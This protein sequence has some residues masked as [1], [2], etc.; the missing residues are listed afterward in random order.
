MEV[1]SLLT[2]RTP[3][4]TSVSLHIT[5]HPVLQHFEGLRRFARVTGALG[6][7]WTAIDGGVEDGLMA[8]QDVV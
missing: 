7:I 5:T 8:E 3:I 6:V 4:S 1:K 2:R